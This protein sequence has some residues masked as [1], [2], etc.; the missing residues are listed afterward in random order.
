L[1]YDQGVL[2]GNKNRHQ[3]DPYEWDF[4]GLNPDHSYAAWRYELARESP[5]INEGM[6]LLSSER[7]REIE[8][9]TEEDWET[10]RPDWIDE[11]RFWQ[12]EPIFDALWRCVEFPKPWMTL[13]DT[14]LNIAV[15]KYGES[16]RPVRILT[17]DEF[18]RIEDFEQV[19]AK[20]YERR[21]ERPLSEERRNPI[22]RYIIEIDWSK[23]DPL[24]KPLLAGL[25][26]LR[27]EGTRPF[28]RHTGKRAAEPLHLFKQLAAWRLATKA[29]LNYK[30]ARQLVDARRK[31]VQENDRFDLLPDYKSAGAWKDAVDAGRRRVKRA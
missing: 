17:R 25:L 6:A 11:K 21:E 12:F 24:L 5:Y 7:R 30:E 4:R 1:N 10:W 20:L 28:K 26:R 19:I 31:E 27:P 18:R 13:P 22:G 2:T 3:L 15:E 23:D 8:M 16:P 29:S 14:V 9:L